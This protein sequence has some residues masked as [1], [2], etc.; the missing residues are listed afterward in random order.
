MSEQGTGL[1]VVCQWNKEQFGSDEV[2]SPNINHH[3]FVLYLLDDE[4]IENPDEVLEF[5]RSKCQSPVSL[6][7]VDYYCLSGNEMVG[8]C[9]TFWLKMIQRK[10][11][12]IFAERR[13][14]EKLR[15]L[16]KSLCYREYY[17]QWEPELNVLP[18]I[19]GML[20]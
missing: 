17:G 2:T 5:C 10:W 14:I 19:Q 3:W 4:E 20:A 15:K 7:I 13:R 8:I 16:P 18:T 1:A 9:K 6:Q 12:K 11:K